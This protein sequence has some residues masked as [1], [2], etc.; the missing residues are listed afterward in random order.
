MQLMFRSN[1]MAVFVI[2][3]LSNA[4]VADAMSL[5]KRSDK[6]G[7]V[8]VSDAMVLVSKVHDDIDYEVLK[9][10]SINKTSTVDCLC[11]LGSFWNWRIKAC[12]KQG[13]WGYECDSSLRN[14]ISKSVKMA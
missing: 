10:S 1:A 11:P 3:L 9:K 2:A 6:Q 12:V 4:F 8:A 5:R 13:A 14:T 7:L